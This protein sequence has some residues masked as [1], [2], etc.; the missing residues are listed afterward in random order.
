MA[1]R[2][3]ISLAPPYL[4]VPPNVACPPPLHS[5]LLASSPLIPAANLAISL[6]ASV[7]MGDLLICMQIVVTCG[8]DGDLRGSFPEQSVKFLTDAS[9]YG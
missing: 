1:L 9:A 2:N 5:K 3:L 7:W 6:P 4:L 8:D